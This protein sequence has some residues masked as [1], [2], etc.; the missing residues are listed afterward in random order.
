MT[1]GRLADRTGELETIRGRLDEFRRHHEDE[2]AG[3]HDPAAS[4]PTRA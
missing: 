2:L 1:I 4:D 3:R